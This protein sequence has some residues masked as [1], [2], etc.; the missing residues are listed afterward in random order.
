MGRGGEGQSYPAVR[1][2]DYPELQ[3]ELDR[4]GAGELKIE[5]ISY[6]PRSAKLRLSLYDGSFKAKYPMAAGVGPDWYFPSGWDA[7]ASAL[8]EFFQA[9][10][11]GTGVEGLKAAARL[12]QWGYEHGFD[13]GEEYEASKQSDG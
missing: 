8:R 7:D 1:S 11:S 10:P 9:V 6:G 4:I 5:E 12:F 13:A 2:A 3:A